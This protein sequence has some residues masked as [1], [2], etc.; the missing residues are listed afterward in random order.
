VGYFGGTGEILGLG[1]VTFEG[2]DHI[3][4]GNHKYYFYKMYSRTRNRI[5]SYNKIIKV[6]FNGIMKLVFNYD[7]I[8]ITAGISAFRC[9]KFF[10]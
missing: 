10:G 9:F 4:L 7:C 5:I 2:R 8:L 6:D 1:F 3:G